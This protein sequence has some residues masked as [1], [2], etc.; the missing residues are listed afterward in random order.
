MESLPDIDVVNSSPS[1][2]LA[3]PLNITIQ[4]NV[5]ENNNS[6]SQ[7]Q[8]HMETIPVEQIDLINAKSQ[9]RKCPDII[10]DKPF[11]ESGACPLFIKPSKQNED[12]DCDLIPI[13]SSRQFTFQSHL[14]SLY[15][16][17]TKYKLIIRELK[18]DYHTS[19]ASKLITPYDWWLNTKVKIF[20]LQYNFLRPSSYDL[21]TE[22]NDANFLPYQTKKAHHVTYQK[23]LKYKEPEKYLFFFFRNIH[24][25]SL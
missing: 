9:K 1:E 18:N 15:M 16:I 7:I 3:S 23:F 11:M 4:Q 19:I 13:L 22:E 5:N 6:S 12:Q 14:T 10:A 25:F 20:S 21:R 24:R 17:P 2:L 8:E